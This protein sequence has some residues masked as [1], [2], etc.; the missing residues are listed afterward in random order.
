[1]VLCMSLFKNLLQMHLNDPS[2]M[3]NFVCI[4]FGI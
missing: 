1:M 2:L 4:G 3:F